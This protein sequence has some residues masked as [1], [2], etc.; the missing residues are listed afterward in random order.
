MWPPVMPLRLERTQSLGGEK[1]KLELGTSVRCTDGATQ[2]LVDVVIDSS[3]NRVT[4]LVIRPAQDAEDARLVPVSLA[5]GAEKDGETEISLNCSAADLERFDPVHQVEVLPA[6]ERR[7]E[8]P[9]WDVGVEDIIVSPNYAPSAFG[10]YV[11]AVDSDATISYDRVPKGEIELRH[12]SSVYSADGH[13]LG[14]VD[15]VVVDDADR[16]TH[17]LVERGHL[18]WRREVALPAEAISK[19]ESDMLTLG[20][21]KREF[22]KADLSAS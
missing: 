13:R 6:G 8:D 2:E 21:T 5:N 18:W 16:L 7:D 1:M 19:F 22:A 11:G 17:L 3:S 14:S 10:D 20:V 4:H 15:G 12:A 9:K